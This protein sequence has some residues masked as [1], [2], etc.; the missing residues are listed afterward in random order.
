MKPVKFCLLLLTV[1]I[2]VAANA[3]TA[4]EIIA[5][6]IEATG[7]KEKL[8]AINSVIIENTVH[9]MDNDSPNKIIVSNGKGYRTE[10]DFNGQKLVQVYTD[11]GG[12]AINPFEGGDA[13]VAMPADQYKSGAGLVYAVPLF[14]YAARNEKAELLGQEKVGNANAYKIKVTDKDNIIITYFIDASTYYII[15]TIRPAQMMGQSMDLTTTYS[16]FKKSEYGWVVPQV[17]EINYGG[18]FS[19]TSR[20]NKIEINAPVDAA[21]F[22]MK[23]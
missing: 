23:K 3:Q 22:E 14:N 9:V 20:A 6:H 2:S 17:S 10:S 8:G 4:D 19:M 5:R 7:G 12:W 21:V 11:K 18:Q 13:A 16:D 1:L 15:Q